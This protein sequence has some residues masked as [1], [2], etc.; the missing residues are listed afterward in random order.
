MANEP[1]KAHLS[2][3]VHKKSERRR[4]VKTEI[5]AETEVAKSARRSKQKGATK[6][7]R[8]GRA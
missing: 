6:I 7:K 4:A 8:S 3:R 2:Y 5:A 1:H